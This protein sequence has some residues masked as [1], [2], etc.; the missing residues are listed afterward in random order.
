[1]EES[2]KISKSWGGARIGA[3]RKKVADKREIV[4]I[5]VRPD[6]KARLKAMADAEGIKIGEL[7]TRWV[8]AL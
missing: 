6:I 8:E 4:S 7:V 3:G 2:A 1:M 5:Y